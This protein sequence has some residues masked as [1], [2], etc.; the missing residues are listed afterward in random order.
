MTFWVTFEMNLSTTEKLQIFPMMVLLQ[1][2]PHFPHKTARQQLEI[3]KF[4]W[5]MTHHTRVQPCNSACS[6]VFLLHSV[7]RRGKN[8]PDIL[9]GYPEMGRIT[10]LKSPFFGWPE[11]TPCC[12]VIKLNNAYC[13]LSNAYTYIVNFNSS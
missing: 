7:E 6:F 8:C 1:N 4:T 9:K 11:S 10:F 12:C 13:T 2:F 5:N 3:G